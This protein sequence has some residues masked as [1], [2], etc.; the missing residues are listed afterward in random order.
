[1]RTGEVDVLVATST[2]ELGVNMPVRQVVLYDAHQFDGERFRPISVNAAWQRAGRAGRAGVDA[3]GEAVILAARWDRDLAR[4]ME[5][6]FEPILSTLQNEG[7]LA[8]QIVAEVDSGLGSTTEQLERA[9]AQSL[10][11]FQS[12]LPPLQPVVRS[13]EEAGLI[14]EVAGHGGPRVR[15][16]RLGRVA[17][18][19][20]LMPATVLYMNRLLSTMADPTFFDLLLIIAATPDCQPIL[21]V[22]YEELSA[23]AER[24]QSEPSHL[25]ALAGQEAFARDLTGRRVLST[26]KTSLA[27]RRWTRTGDAEHTAEAFGC[28]SYEIAALAESAH[29]LLQ[30]LSVVVQDSASPLAQDVADRADALSKMVAAGLDEESVTLSLVRGIGATLA[31]RLAQ[32]GVTDV[33]ELACSDPADLASIPGI[34]AQRA[35]KWVDDAEGIVRT[36]SAFHYREE[37]APYVVT[38]HDWPPEVEPYRFRRALDLAVKAI[39]PDYEVSGGLDPHVVRKQVLRCDC[40]DAASGSVCKHVLAVRLFRGD[41]RLSRL[42]RRLELNKPHTESGLDLA[43]L[44]L[45]GNNPATVRKAG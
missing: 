12:R 30:A 24:L 17:S 2:L 32:N 15:A 44:W 38:V 22:D 3:A 23:L 26:L 41:A 37:R 21:G 20:M 34:S 18:R 42:R 39:G 35:A 45:A 10:A 9:L 31:R 13:M 40:R 1:M 33:E 16:T 14:V 25:L 27:L 6:R 36:V 11:S 7:A 43:R 4:L 5:G 8:E 29:R 28:Y 19:Y